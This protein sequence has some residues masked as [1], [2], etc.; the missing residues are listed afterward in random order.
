MK[1]NLQALDVLL[2]GV[3]DLLELLSSSLASRDDGV[4]GLLSQ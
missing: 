3:L 2:H 4:L 1:T